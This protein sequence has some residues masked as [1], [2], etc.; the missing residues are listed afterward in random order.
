[1]I[2]SA[3]Q[4]RKGGGE[5]VVQP[6]QK[7]VREERKSYTAHVKVLLG[8]HKWGDC[9]DLGNVELATFYERKVI[10][11]LGE[12]ACRFPPLRLTSFTL[13]HSESCKDERVH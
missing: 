5:A 1:L 4:Q 11:R 8:P 3:G 10:T 13:F 12:S 2:L 6:Q 9:T 7:G